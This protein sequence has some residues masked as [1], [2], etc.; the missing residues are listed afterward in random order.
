[1]GCKWCRDCGGKAGYLSIEHPLPATVE[2]PEKI[3]ELPSF[4]RRAA[5]PGTLGPML[6]IT[7]TVEHS[8]A[9]P[10]E[11]EDATY[12]PSPLEDERERR[13]PSRAEAKATAG[14]SDPD[15]DREAEGV[16]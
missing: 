9:V 7:A 16:E 3:D 4:L 2:C 5:T 10:E 13:Q 8:L 11:I 14:H 12:A 6:Y 15:T 1:M